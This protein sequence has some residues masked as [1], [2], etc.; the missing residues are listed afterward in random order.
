MALFISLP[1][2]EVADCIESP[3]R[4]RAR[5]GWLVLLILIFG[6][7]GVLHAERAEAT[8]AGGCYWCMQEPFEDIRGVLDTDV[9]FSGGTTVN[10]NYDEVT[11]GGTGHYEVVH[12]VYDDDRV[13]YEKLLDVFW[14]NVDPYDPGGQ[15][16][17][18]GASYRTAI[19][20]HTP[21]QKRIATSSKRKY[22][23]VHPERIVTPTIQFSAFY[24]AAE[25]HQDYHQKNPARY[26]TYRF[27]CGRDKRLE[28]LWGS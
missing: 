20:Y 4:K 15:F 11:R 19:F 3:R 5:I 2:H 16:C 10:P 13:T 18:R 7:G 25:Y 28:E 14:E 1:M 8:F 6:I 9:G 22:A 24:P 12:V 26:K 21:A 27:L 17:D 23:K